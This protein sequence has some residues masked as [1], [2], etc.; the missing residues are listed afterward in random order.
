VREYPRAERLLAERRAAVEK[1]NGRRSGM[2]MTAELDAAYL[3][4][5]SGKPAQA[6]QFLADAFD[7]TDGERRVVLETGTEADHAA[8]LASASYQLDLVINFGLRHAP[9][10]GSAARLGLTTVLRSKGRAIDAAASSLGAIRARMSP[11]DAQLLDELASARAQLARLTVAGPTATGEADFA[12][13]V[14]AYDDR[15]QKLEIAVGKA[16]AAYRVASQPIELAAVQKAIPA[17]ARLVEI[18]N[19][20]PADP[21]VP[22]TARPVAEPRRYAAYVVGRTGDPVLIDLGP[23]AAIDETIER[24]RAAVSNPEDAATGEPAHALYALTMAKIAP[25][26]GGATSV[27]IAPDGALNVVPFA[28]LTDDRGMLLIQRTTFTYLTSGRDLLRQGVKTRPRSAGAIFADATFDAAAAP[29]PAAGQRGRRS[30]EL[31]AQVWSRLPGTGQEAD[32]IARQLRGVPIYRGA[33]ATETA[34]KAV[35]GPRL[36]HLAT[37][38]FFLRDEAPAGPAPAGAPVNL[39]VSGARENPLLRSG[40]V[41]AGANQLASGD[42]DGILTALEAAGLDLWGT[43]LVV[44]S[45]CE[46]GVGKVTHGDGVYG[47]R[48]ALAIAGAESLVMSLWQVDDAATR[49]L[50]TGYYA[51]LAAGRPR[52]SAL[53]DVQLALLR[54]P[55]YAHPYYWASFLPAGDNA[56]L[57]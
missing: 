15:I 8:Y 44:L 14:A 29:S 26:L 39:A 22:Y 17:D 28:A 41:F 35:H 16:S 10:R 21:A 25:A 45:A 12:R 13:E 53:R 37:H 47:L 9:R 36:L 38:G 20:Q 3:S 11:G 54:T 48:R 31:S 34:L 51:R 33:R 32:A 52:S 57:Q 56:P 2:Y 23:A 6:E 30:S 46:T 7:I 1:A 49:D 43:Q 55:K 42:D 18:V 40:L 27:L 4:M 50:M 19:F 5:A 24:F